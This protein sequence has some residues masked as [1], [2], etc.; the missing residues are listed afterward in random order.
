LLIGAIIT[1]VSSF[2]TAFITWW[3]DPLSRRRRDREFAESVEKWMSGIFSAHGVMMIGNDVEDRNQKRSFDLAYA[4][5]SSLD[6]DLRFRS[7]R[8]QFDIFVRPSGES[9]GW[10]SVESIL[11]LRDQSPTPR[12]IYGASGPRDVAD[13]LEQNW[14][15][16]AQAMIHKPEDVESVPQRLKPSTK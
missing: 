10:S 14:D 4:T 5:F 9:R 7:I 15:T 1:V 13:L 3:L 12:K 11:A 2:Y 16:L 6:F 8:G